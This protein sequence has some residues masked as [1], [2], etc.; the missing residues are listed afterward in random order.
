MADCF[1]VRRGGGINTS[2]ATATASDILDGKT[3]YVNK[4]KI[5]GNIPSKTSATYQPSNIE[6]TITSGQYL[7]GT[8]TIAP[9]TGDA[10]PEFVAI[11]KTF[12][13]GT[14]NILQIGTMPNGKKYATGTVGSN[15]TLLTFKY[16][17]GTD[18]SRPYVTVSGLTFKPGF[19][20][21]KYSLGT[22]EAI[23]V[24]ECISGGYYPKCVK[25]SRYNNSFSTQQSDNIKGDVA[26]VN[27]AY[28]T[29]TLPV[30][31]SSSNYKFEAHEE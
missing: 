6:Q 1:I 13:S 24:Y 14:S 22:D 12:Y 18:V 3:A 2:D 16:L 25:V 9:V 10:T 4:V 28:G 23:S 26:P 17:S 31:Y 11:G 30:P 29:F 21:I 27:V 8:Q 19:V 5:T 7:S 15:S 20:I